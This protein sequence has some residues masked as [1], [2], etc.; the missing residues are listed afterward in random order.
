MVGVSYVGTKGTNLTQLTTPNLGPTLLQGIPVATQLGSPGHVFPLVPPI[1]MLNNLVKNFRRDRPN[2]SL[3]AFQLFQNRASSSY[4]SFQL[5]ARQRF[6]SGLNFT[7]AYTWSHAIDDVSDIF[8]M[9]GAPVLAQDQ[10]NL[11]LDRGNASFDMPQRLAISLIWDLP[12]Y[13][14]AGRGSARWL[15][16]WQLSSIF[17]YGSGQPFT[18]NLPLD[19]NLDGNLTDRPSTTNGLV[20]FSGHGPQ[21][22]AIAPGHTLADFF[23]LGQD[24]AVGR[25][26]A[27][28]DS[29]VNWDLAVDKV[30]RFTENQ[31]LD[32]R[33]EIFNLMNRANFGLPI[34][35]LS[36]PGFGSAVETINPARVIQF[37]LKYSF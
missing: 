2:P 1:V 17:Q 20:F 26:T 27:R 30:F 6:S 15:G 28:G 34:R 18:L 19:A 14:N 31:S 37:A 5:E 29:F 13:R 36:A 9:A 35:V 32:F 21:R 10:N 7:V 25:N 16:G 3:G 33:T 23:V 12:F 11:R 8:P 22:V 4:N 24:G